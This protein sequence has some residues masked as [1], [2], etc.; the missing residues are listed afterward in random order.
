MISGLLI[1]TYPDLNVQKWITVAGVLNHAD[2][3]EYFGDDAL[4]K[5][6]NMNKLPHV[7]QLHYIADG[8]TV[9]PNQLSRQWAKQSDIIV[10][11]DA[12]HDS[13]R[14]IDLDFK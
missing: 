4:N 12:D 7:P 10:I 2:W 13:L 6:L 9:V 3:T 11:D 8:D 14:D 5:S 1:Q